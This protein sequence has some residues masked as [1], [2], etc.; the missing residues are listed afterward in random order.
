[1]FL[2]NYISFIPFI[3]AIFFFGPTSPNAA[4]KTKLIKWAVQ[5]EST[6]TIAGKSNVNTFG[7]DVVRYNKPDTILCSPEDPTSKLV[8]LNGSRL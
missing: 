2:L 5:N 3:S 1:M 4:S 7:C 8:T 6:L